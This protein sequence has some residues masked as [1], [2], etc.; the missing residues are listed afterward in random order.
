MKQSCNRQG[1]GRNLALAIPQSYD[2]GNR[3]PTELLVDARVR[4]RGLWRHQRDLAQRRSAGA[5]RRRRIELNA[6]G[7]YSSGGDLGYR[8]MFDHSLQFAGLLAENTS[9]FRDTGQS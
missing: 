5:D 3:T 6:L 7:G 4:R 8:M 2:R 9:P 1:R